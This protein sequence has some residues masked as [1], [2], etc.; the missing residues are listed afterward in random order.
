MAVTT[1]NTVSYYYP[2]GRIVTV[3][4]MPDGTVNYTESRL[5]GIAPAKAPA[6]EPPLSQPPTNQAPSR[7]TPQREKL[8]PAKSFDMTIEPSIPRQ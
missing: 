1:G 3:T 7:E 2:D 8:I 6:T 5:T 4:T